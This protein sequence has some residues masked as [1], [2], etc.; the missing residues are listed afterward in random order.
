MSETGLKS[1]IDM[2]VYYYK[3]INVRRDELG[4]DLLSKLITSEIEREDGQMAPLSTSRS[5][6]SQRCWVEPAQRP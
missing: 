3:L 1:A 4:D 5:P 6:S 2:A